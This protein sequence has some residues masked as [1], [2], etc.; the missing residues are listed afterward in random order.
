MALD[1]SRRGPDAD[2]TMT[3]DLVME[4]WHRPPTNQKKMTALLRCAGQPATR[5]LI[6]PFGRMIQFAG[7]AIFPIPSLWS[8]HIWLA[9]GVV[10]GSAM[11]PRWHEC[12]RGTASR[13]RWVNKVVFRILGLRMIRDPCCWKF[14]RALRHSDTIKTG[15]DPE[16]AIMRPVVT[17]KV[18]ANPLGNIDVIEGGRCIFAQGAGRIVPDEAEH[19]E[20]DLWAKTIRAARVWLA[21]R[22]VTVAAAQIFL[23][24]IPALLIGLARSHGIWHMVICGWLQHGGRADSFLDRR[25]N[26]R[27]VFVSPVG[28]F[29]SWNMNCDEEHQVFPL[30]PYCKMPDLYEA[31]QHSFPARNC[32][33]ASGFAEMLPVPWCQ[34]TDSD[35]HLRRPVRETANTCHDGLRAHVA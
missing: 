6:V 23:S 25:L 34:R 31:C 13:T 26:R 10:R 29:A 20:W 9:H 5:K 19:V 2:R 3:N 16:A 15:Q 1:Y 32:T 21:I 18:A 17:L 11:N 28:R 8:A 4:D 14:G 24:R 22:A 35:C 27:S 12:G 33:M 7:L 30:V